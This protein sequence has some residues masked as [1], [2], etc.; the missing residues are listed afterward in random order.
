M[1]EVYI[2]DTAGIG[3]YKEK[4]FF[5]ESVSTILQLVVALIEGQCIFDECS[6]VKTS[7]HSRKVWHEIC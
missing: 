2:L 5:N 3:S 6:V 1:G 7:P 4:V